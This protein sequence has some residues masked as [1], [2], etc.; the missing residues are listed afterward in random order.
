MG[1]C[2]N[3]KIRH[4]KSR[5]RQYGRLRRLDNRRK[6]G[7]LRTRARIAFTIGRRER[8]G[9]LPREIGEIHTEVRSFFLRFHN[10]LVKLSLGR[11]SKNN[12]KFPRMH[13]RGRGS[14]Q[15]SDKYVFSRDR[16]LLQQQIVHLYALP[17]NVENVC[18]YAHT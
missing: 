3:R 15:G 9:P 13:Q 10:T 14:A 11:G 16:L 18:M 8:T 7:I 5:R 2:R 4:S 6:Y 1:G 17:K 12:R